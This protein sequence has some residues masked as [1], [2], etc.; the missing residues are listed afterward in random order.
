MNPLLKV[1]DDTPEYGVSD[2]GHIHV[3]DIC[4]RRG[5]WGMGWSWYGDAD[6]NDV[7]K[8]CGCESISEAKAEKLLKKKQGAK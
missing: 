4:G 6:E 8:V 3:C 2:S 7:L 5:R 1:F